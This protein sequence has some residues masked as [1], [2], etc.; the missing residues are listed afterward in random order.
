[1]DT[2]P[3][4]DATIDYGARIVTMI[5]RR[6]VVGLVNA[7][8]AFY[9]IGAL[10]P[11]LTASPNA[12]A[13]WV[14]EGAQKPVVN[15]PTL[16]ALRVPARKVTVTVPYSVEF[17]RLTHARVDLAVNADMT[18]A[19][20]VAEDSA[21][22]DAAPGDAARPASIFYEHV[23]TG[24]GDPQT[25]FAALIARIPEEYLAD[26]VLLLNAADCVALLTAG[27]ADNQTLSVAS[28]GLVAGLPAVVSGG[29][30]RGAIGWCVP[31]L[32][33][34]VDE[35]SRIT[36]S[37]EATLEMT[38]GTLVSL[39]ESDLAALRGE[40]WIAWA[41]LANNVAGMMTGVLASNLA[42]TKRAKA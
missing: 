29:V 22:C 42:P 33:A 35:G 34:L 14:A 5:E 40:R 21:F 4:G 37:D 30:P 7:I 15:G 18:H 26:V 6:S 16:D 39:W 2:M 24:T 17:L 3:D 38:D 27:L 8:H 41:P 13:Q 32:I 23:I 10:E 9:R 25:D 20:R 31:R 36:S 11:I 28:G 1:M 12:V 19:L